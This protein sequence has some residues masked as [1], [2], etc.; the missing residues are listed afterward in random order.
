MIMLYDDKN[1]NDDDD[2]NDHDH[3]DVNDYH[4]QTMMMIW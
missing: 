2:D 3:D 1:D 4:D